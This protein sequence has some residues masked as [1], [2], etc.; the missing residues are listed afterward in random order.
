MYDLPPQTLL[1]QNNARPRSGEELEVL[2]KKASA[3]YLCG[4]CATMNDAVVETVKKAG[5]SPEQVRRVIEFAN[6]DAY[7]KEFEKKGSTHKYIAFQGG[8][9][10]PSEILKDLNDGGGGTVFDRGDG[11]YDQA[12]MHKKASVIFQRNREA[13]QKL[14]FSTSQPMAYPTMTGEGT[15]DQEVA[16]P[17]A[18][19]QG[20]SLGS[21][22]AGGTA[23]GA[24]GGA[25]IGYAGA[26]KRVDTMKDLAHTHKVL[27]RAGA[28]PIP[29]S[30]LEEAAKIR[31]E[32][33]S[34]EHAAVLR[35]KA[36]RLAGMGKKE[37]DTLARQVKLERTGS[38]ALR[39][40][41]AGL[42][43][44][45]ALY[46]GYK[47]LK[48]LKDRAT[49]AAAEKE[50]V[51]S[52]DF[53]PAETAFEEMWSVKEIPLPYAN[54][55]ED[56]AAMREKLSSIAD[57]LRYELSSAES[58]HESALLDLYQEVKQA[59][60]EGV[61][62][63]HVLQAWQSIVPGE[64]FVK[65]AFM[66][67]GPRLVKEGIFESLEDL[68]GS[69]E[70]V[71]SRGL[72]VNMDHPLISTFAA[73]CENLEKMAT[74]RAERGAV[75][76]ELDY[77]NTFLK[78]AGGILPDMFHDV[79]KWTREEAAP[80]VQQGVGTVLGDTAGRAAGF[81]TRFAPHIGV[82]LGAKELWDRASNSR[83]ANFF[84]SRIPGTQEYYMRQLALSQNP[85]LF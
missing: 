2:G 16:V 83:V 56:V 57:E 27:S 15:A 60:A 40:L 3:M 13:M 36:E 23:A 45:G 4:S 64:G 19:Q 72:M 43:G 78:E 18:Q 49:A 24:V 14:A 20:L 73:Y 52:V 28:G 81:L 70:K 65:T 12:P 26:K 44:A 68:G 5:L 39:G 62:L 9:A 59:S 7:I 1:Q 42:L 22:L 31:G 46:G 48:A 53:N 51:A 29:L 63:G 8:P 34:P 84:Q 54:P 76:G 74:L 32:K 66:F 47:G 79:T 50:A 10:N 30:H 82:G 25:G 85:D 71:A 75:L 11:H 67:I 55:F 38:G 6:T 35:Q 69:I 58:F 33:F 61:P 17:T 80:V 37:V 21:V 77:V 41:G